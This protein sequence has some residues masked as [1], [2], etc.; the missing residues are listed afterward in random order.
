MQVMSQRPERHSESAPH[1][2]P[3]DFVPT[4]PRPAEL[5]GRHTLPPQTE[6][7]HTEL[8]EPQASLV[9]QPR[10]QTFGPV[11]PNHAGSAQNMSLGQAVLSMHGEPM[12]MTVPPS[13]PPVPASLPPVPP[14]APLNGRVR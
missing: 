8:P 4:A 9:Q 3:T 12:P 6:G 10:V 11:P 2:M 1:T 5:A 13:P 7:K 14:V